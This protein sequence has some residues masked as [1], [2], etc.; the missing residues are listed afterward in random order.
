MFVLLTNLHPDKDIELNCTWAHHSKGAMDAIGGTLMNKVFR[1]VKSGRIIVEGP[2]DFA[3]HVSS[4]IESIATLYFQKSETHEE[5]ADVE[6][7]LCFKGI[8]DFHKVKRK[9]M[10]KV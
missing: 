5:P 2:K 4:L 10:S 6:N 1:K 9:K 3:M 7:V 8:L